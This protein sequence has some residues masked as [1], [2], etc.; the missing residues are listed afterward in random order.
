MTNVRKIADLNF[1]IYSLNANLQE[2]ADFPN[3]T[4]RVKTF[5]IFQSGGR[6]KLKKKV[7]FI[8]DRPGSG[9]P[10]CKNVVYILIRSL[11][12]GDS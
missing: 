4:G 1:T 11:S 8:C 3:T 6:H 10:V 12:L 2:K 5:T 9:D 7:N